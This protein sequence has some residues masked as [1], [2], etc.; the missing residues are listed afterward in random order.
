MGSRLV[1]RDDL[2]EKETIT[3]K[4]GKYVNNDKQKSVKT[5]NDKANRATV[6]QVLD[7]RTIRFVKKL[8]SNGLI[9]E[10]NGTISTGKEANVYHCYN[11]DTNI[12]YALKIYK[13]SILVFKDR[14]RYIANEYR[15]QNNTSTNPR[16]MI[17]LWAEKEFRNLNRLYANN[18]PCPKPIELKSHALLM[19]YLTKGN[20]EPSPKLKDYDFKNLDQI[21]FFYHQMIIY[22]RRMFQE[23][24]L[25][26]ADLS[27]YNSIIHNGK[28]YIIDV[29]QSVEPEHP[30]S[31]DFLRM[32]IKNINDFF[33]KK[34]LKD[35]AIISEKSI[36][37][38]IIQDIKNFN[39]FNNSIDFKNIIS[40][41]KEYFKILENLPIKSSS[42]KDD[43]EDEIFRSIHLV[44]SLNHLEERDFEEYSQGNIDTLKKLSIDVVHSS[45]SDY[46]DSD[47]DTDSDTDTENHLHDDDDDDENQE[48][49]AKESW[50]ERP[51]ELKGKKYEDKTFKKERKKEQKDLAREKR[52][53]KMKKHVKKKLVAKSSSNKN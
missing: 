42:Y 27:E 25:V 33:T 39:N 12:E 1:L 9:T 14:S 2:K 16:K 34:G 24:K 15:F 37:Q 48:D 10:M 26:H 21:I 13:T 30:M 43:L 32:D 17:K 40:L 47:S 49:S 36:F 53:T 35:I 28:L 7:P 3:E 5:I 46:T 31:L 18:I 44:R 52:K 4:Y 20:H 11:K 23:C 29:S 38:F 41:E 45:D 6:D 50:E 8:F 22:M 19:E 51:K